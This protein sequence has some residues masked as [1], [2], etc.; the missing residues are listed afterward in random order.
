LDERAT[1]GPTEGERWAR[2][3]LDALRTAGFAPAAI[4][5]FLAASQRRA[6][7]R[8]AQRPELARQARRWI[9]AGVLAWS[10]PAL[11]GAQPF[12]RRARSGMAWWTLTGLMLDW[13][14][15]MVETADG[16]ARPLGPADACT[17]V[18]AWLVPVA[19]DSPTPLVCGVAAASDVLDGVLARAAEPTRI[20]RDLE[21][22]AD[23]AFAIAALRGAARRGWLGR[24]PAAVEVARLAGGTAYAFAEY[25]RSSAPPAPG[26][27]RATR[28]TALPRTAGLIAAGLGHRRPAGALVAIGAGSS[29]AAAGR[30]VLARAATEQA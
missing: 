24:L 6:H 9:A 4:A 3:Q 18:R 19:A 29:L 8:R 11:A 22:L 30:A 17:L 27:T 21:G 7:E 20:G 1:S 14:L 15:G 16:R 23:V 2:E 25:F 10:A 5:R 13:H 26:L 28:V 12:R